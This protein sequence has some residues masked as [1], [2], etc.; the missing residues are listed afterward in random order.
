[1]FYCRR[2]CCCTLQTRWHNE[3]RTLQERT[4]A[5]S[6]GV[7]P[8]TSELLLSTTTWVRHLTRLAYWSDT[9]VVANV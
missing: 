9:L 8:V 5:Q 3:E 2:D 7:S 4:Q 1:M 6:E